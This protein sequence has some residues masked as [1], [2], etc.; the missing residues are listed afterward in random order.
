MQTFTANDAKQKF[1]LVMDS[2]LQAPVTI[3][4][5]GRP[6][7]VITS[8]AEYRELLRLKH[9]SLREDVA[10]G[11]KSLDEQGGV[12]ARDEAELA[13]LMDQVKSR[14]REKLG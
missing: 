8:D 5:H 9:Q 2:A 14:G 1:G 10:A 7:V 11:F 6:A 13:K 4:K 12:T 3:T